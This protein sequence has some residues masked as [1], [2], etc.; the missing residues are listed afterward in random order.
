MLP[1]PPVRAELEDTLALHVATLYH[2]GLAQRLLESFGS[3]A[4]VLRQK[5]R[6]LERAASL[7][8]TTV[9]KILAPATRTAASRELRRAAARGVKVLVRGDP[10]YPASLLPL[11]AMPLVLYLEGFLE[12]PSS[13]PPEV[14]LVGIVGTRRPTPY[15]ARQARRFAEGLVRRGF[16]VVSGLAAG[17]DGEAHRGA[18]DARGP[19][20]AVLGSGLDRL[21]PPQ[22]APLARAILDSGRGAVVTEHPFD[23]VPLSRHFPLRNRIISGLSQAVL[24]VEAGE[25]SGSLITAR[26]AL[27]QGK[28]IYV[29]PGRICPEALGG[30]RLLADGATPALEPFD[31][32]PREGEPAGQEGISEAPRAS[33]PALDGP[34]AEGLL[35]LFR[36]EEAWNAD[37]IAERLCASP[38]LVLGELSRLEIEGAL[39]RG[40]GGTYS[41]RDVGGG[42]G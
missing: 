15:A 14:P 24:I 40:P 11:D 3:A 17:I 2:P 29:V 5:P 37:G 6:T 28:S 18:L 35:L 22:H 27:E 4:E 25:R 10:A 9:Q 33:G 39:Q 16:V 31:V 20:V 7:P 42:R 8:R 19:T 32:L 38:E 30:L 41:L 21:Y 23:A 34:L 26:Y 13:P 36:E 12:S 1:F